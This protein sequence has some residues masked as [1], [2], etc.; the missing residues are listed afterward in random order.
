[1]RLTFFL[2]SRYGIFRLTNGPGL[3]YILKCNQTATF[4]QHGIDNLYT[5]AVHPPGHV[6]ESSQ[7]DFKVEDLRTSHTK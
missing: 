7:L 1:M 2:L 6:Y 3:D 4:H 5:S